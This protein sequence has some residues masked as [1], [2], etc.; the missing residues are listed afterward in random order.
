MTQPIIATDARPGCQ[1]IGCNR[2]AFMGTPLCRQC[3]RMTGPL[4][5]PA[6]LWSQVAYTPA[7][8][9]LWTGHTILNGYGQVYH[10][11]RSQMIHR[12]VYAAAK[13]AIPQGL[14]LDHLCRNRLCV[15]PDHL[16]PVTNREN[17]I[18]GARAGIGSSRFVGVSRK[19]NKWVAQLNHDRIGSYSTE[20]AAARAYDAA[21][22][23]AHGPDAT[24]NAT[25]GLYDQE[26][27]A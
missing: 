2:V 4:G 19:R 10:D 22:I 18:R 20:Q 13:G 9:W 21:V 7:G 8:C 16:D 11:G 5:L 15:N 17:A 14:D 3:G 1:A 26:A 6:R 25:L 12:I 23:A 24:T 27:A